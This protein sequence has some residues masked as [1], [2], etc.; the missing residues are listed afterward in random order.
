MWAAFIIRDKVVGWY[1]KLKSRVRDLRTLRKGIIAWLRLLC[2][3]TN[4]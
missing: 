1:C 3:F 4:L 2:Y